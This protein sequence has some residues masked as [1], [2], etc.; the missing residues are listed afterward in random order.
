LRKTRGLLAVFPKEAL[1]GGNFHVA[2]G[3]FVERVSPPTEGTFC[4]TDAA[5]SSGLS[6]WS[7]LYLWPFGR[8]GATNKKGRTGSKIL[9]ADNYQAP[10]L[11]VKAG[12][13]KKHYC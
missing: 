5:L 8:V 4:N 13:H 11:M 9:A 1:R 12:R 6:M 2:A 7:G 3:V 10:N